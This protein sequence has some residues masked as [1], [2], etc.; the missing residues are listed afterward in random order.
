MAEPGFICVVISPDMEGRVCL[1]RSAR[2]PSEHETGLSHIAGVPGTLILAYKRFFSDS[3]EAERSV[4]AFLEQKGYGTTTSRGFFWAALEHVVEAIF[5]A[6]GGT[7]SRPENHS[8][9]GIRATSRTPDEFLDSLVVADSPAWESVFEEAEAKY[10]GFGDEFVDQ[11]EALKLYQQAAQL[12]SATAYRKLGT[13]HRDGEG[14]VRSKSKALEYLKEAARRGDSCSYSEMAQMFADEGQMENARKCWSRFFVDIPEENVGLNCLSYFKA[15]KEHGWPI[16]HADKL[17][18]HFT[19]LRRAAEGFTSHARERHV[20]SPW[21]ILQCE[22]V[23]REIER[24]F[25]R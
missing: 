8:A 16:A 11:E 17:R 3:V 15:C 1:R 22:E 25:G 10:Y 23:E 9:G 12:G 21:Y 14:C 20:D 24:L 2:D 7:D 13:M 18:E 4:R 5:K 6:P 19:D